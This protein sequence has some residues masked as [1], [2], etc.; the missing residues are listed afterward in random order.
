MLA[1]GCRGALNPPFERFAS[2]QGRSPRLLSAAEETTVPLTLTNSGTGAWDPDRV[3]L[4]YHWLWMVPRELASQSRNVPYQ[5][6]IRTELG[7]VMRPGMRVEANGRLLA[8]SLPGVYWLQWDVVE[9]GVTWFSQVS[10]RQPRTLVVVLPA[11]SSMAAVLPLLVAL[12]GISAVGRIE[13]RRQVNPLLFG[14]AMM[15]DACWAAAVLF[16]KPSVLVAETLLEPTGVAYLLMGAAAIVPVLAVVALLPRRSRA[17]LLFALGLF[18]TLVVLADLVYYRFFGDVMSAPALL[19]IGQTPRIGASILSLWSA[20]LFWLLA[21]L[22]FAAWLIAK[23]RRT[24]VFDRRPERPWPVAVAASLVLIVG[25]IG[26]PARRVLASEQLGQMFRARAVMEQLGPLGFHLY[27]SWMYVR[28]TAFRPPLTDDRRAAVTDWFVH[29][30]PLRSGP[31]AYFGVARGMNLIVVQVES[32]Q[33]FVVDYRI[34]DQ[35]VM[36]HLRRWSN[37]SFRFTNV[38]DQTNEGRTSDAEFTTMVSLLPLDHGAVSFRYPEDAYVG[39]PKVLSELGYGTMSAVAFEPGFWN[40]VV[41]HPRYGFERSFF[42]RDFTMTEQIGWGLNDR[43][44][45]QQM[46]PR[47]EAASQPFCAWLITLSLHHPFDSFPD[48]HKVLKLGALEGTPF[49]N[50]LHTMRFFD[51]ALE[52]FKASLA[53]DG[54]LDHTVLAVFGDHDA[55]FTRGPALARTIGVGSDEV[56]WA[57]ADRVPLFIR[58]P[59]MWDARPSVPHIVATPAGQT[60]FAPT[61]LSLLGV[62]ARPLPYM[63]RN[64]LGDPGNPPVLRPYGDWLNSRYLGIDHELNAERLSCYDLA[65]RSLTDTAACEALDREAHEARDV[66]RT[67]ITEGLQQELRSKLAGLIP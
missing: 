34:G 8:P 40:R 64:V 62:D 29:R 63:G 33:D 39:F 35:E 45:L 30:A 52:G 36:P 66:S 6:G 4:S 48:A 58:V 27:D 2:V 49:G 61:L 67:V 22:P 20:R 26:L 60:D 41:M 17:W 65:S 24:W 18:G 12:A 57:L 59:G 46:T 31:S 19:A 43:D 55:G 37:D 10:P 38:T 32:L 1:A 28:T 47:L 5:D 3:H 44:F 53:H 14:F 51:D 11:W 15:A 50:Y 13:R 9:E 16:A 25:G 7:G 21:D 54:L 42:E 23:L 56:S